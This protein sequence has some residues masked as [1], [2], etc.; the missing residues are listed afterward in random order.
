MVGLLVRLKLALLRNSLKRS[1]WRTVGLVFGMLY[2]LFIVGM[3]LVGLGALRFF[4]TPDLTADVTVLAFSALTM[5]W[6]LL[7]LLVFGVDETVDPA[8]FALLP[9]RARELL[10]GLFVSGLVGSPGIATVLVSLGL[11]LAWSRGPAVTIA[12]VLAVPIGVATCF[13]LSRAGTS[14]FSSFLS[15]RKF[16]DIAFVMLAMTGVVFGIGGNL[17]GNFAGRGT[18]PDALR[19][20][21]T[22]AAVVAGWTPF[23]WVWA[24][25]ADV[26]RGAWLSALVHLVLALAL[27]GVLWRTWGYFLAR[28]LTEPIDGGGESTKKVKE[29]SVIER[30]YPATPAGGVA[31]RTLR[32]WRRDPRYLAGVAGFLIAPIILIVTQVANPDGS[33]AVAAFAPVLLGLLIGMSIAQD[34]SY[35]GTALWLHVSS[36][37]RGADD[38]MGRVM[39]TVTVFGPVLL[40]LIVVSSLITQRWDL[41]AQVVGLSVGL[42][43]IGLG[44]GSWV[45]AIW[46]WPAPPPG[47]SP[48][49]R[50]SSGGLPAF[51]SFGLATAGTLV[52]ALPTFAVVIG[53]IWV[54]WLAY[55]ALVVG[56]VSG[57]VVL[58]IGVT[59]GGKLLDRRWPEALAS[60]NERT[61]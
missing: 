51:L 36:G 26:A 16:R 31:G 13:L 8:K 50:G 44:V 49:Q 7:S 32:Y 40:V 17:I 2:A 14:A 33:T 10:P 59:Q 61:G 24:V 25:P 53:S 12:A 48:F 5:G 19:Q 29:Q 34:L 23:G 47:A 3:A 43:L 37:L 30:L 42:G 35:D 52:L 1:V 15:S 18:D 38:R 21:L 54:P 57:V 56:L 28:R 11:V 45:G 39:S 6:L 58:K 60:V 41:M 4:G 27:V 55:V 46:Q 20:G 9:V 22:D